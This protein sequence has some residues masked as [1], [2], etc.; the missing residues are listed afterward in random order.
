MALG[1]L[2]L[3]SWVLVLG[4]RWRLIGSWTADPMPADQ[5]ALGLLYKE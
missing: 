2:V 3:G 5:M 4:S 1:L